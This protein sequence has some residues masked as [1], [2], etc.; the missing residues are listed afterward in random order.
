MEQLQATTY[1][2]YRQLLLID[3]ITHIIIEDTNRKELQDTSKKDMTT[4]TILVEESSYQKRYENKFNKNN[5]KSNG[6]N[7]TVLKL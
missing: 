3:L 2:K 5:F 6:N 4:K 1:H 7:I